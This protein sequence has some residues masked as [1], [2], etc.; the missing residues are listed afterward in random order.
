M[1]TIEDIKKELEDKLLEMLVSKDKVGSE[2]KKVQ[3]LVISQF[4]QLVKDCIPPQ[5]EDFENHQ[6]N[7]GYNC[8]L[9]DIKQSLKA[10]GI[11]LN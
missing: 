10:A 8:C 7:Q 2:I 4:T 9:A 1:K 6:Y 5:D 11:N 3:D